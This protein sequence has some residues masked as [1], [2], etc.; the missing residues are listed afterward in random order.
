M[1]E[2]TKIAFS[3]PS[4][5]DLYDVPY[6]RLSLTLPIHALPFHLTHL[7]LC[8]LPPPPKP[9]PLPLLLTTTHRLGLLRC[10]QEEKSGDHRNIVQVFEAR[11]YNHEYECNESRYDSTLTYE[12]NQII[13][14]HSPKAEDMAKNIRDCRG[15]GSNR[16]L[17]ARQ[18][19]GKSIKNAS[20]KVDKPLATRFRAG[21]E[22][23]QKSDGKSIIQTFGDAK[24]NASA[25][26]IFCGAKMRREKAERH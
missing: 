10:A 2:L 13:L 9:L 20:A 11:A 19:A 22:R 1:A 8:P 21:I 26:V 3:F 12:M 15:L 16:P 25:K 17:V 6:A 23:R 5:P 18:R 4:V 24:L 7:L 14:N